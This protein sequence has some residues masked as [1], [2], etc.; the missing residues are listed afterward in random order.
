MPTGYRC[1][2]DDLG[3]S[4]VYATTAELDNHTRWAHFYYRLGRFF[5]SFHRFRAVE[6]PALNIAP[7][8]TAAI[9]PGAA[10]RPSTAAVPPER[11]IPS[12]TTPAAAAAAARARTAARER[13]ESPVRRRPHTRASVLDTKV[14]PTADHDA[15]RPD[16][17]AATTGGGQPNG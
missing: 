11:A 17:T 10:V 16:L 7:T 5:G 13:G 15:D 1:L 14:A 6:V 9:D 3:C 12:G 2:R 4:A 8:D